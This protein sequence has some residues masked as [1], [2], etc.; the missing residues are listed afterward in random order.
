LEH[1]IPID[2]RYHLKR[3]PSE[4]CTEEELA[5]EACLV[6]DYIDGVTLADGI[7]VFIQKE[8][9]DNHFDSSFFCSGPR[10]TADSTAE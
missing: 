5:Y 9:P 1:G 4:P 2:T 6:A 7:S 3:E 8:K 10:T